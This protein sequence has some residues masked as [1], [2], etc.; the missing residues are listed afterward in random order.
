LRRIANF[1]LWLGLF[2]I[3]LSI[4]AYSTGA[5][6]LDLL[7]SSLATIGAASWILRRPQEPYHPS[8]RFRTLRRLGVIGRDEKE[9]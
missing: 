9:N 8:K 3:F 1:A 6:R 5:G 2:G 4:A 7:L